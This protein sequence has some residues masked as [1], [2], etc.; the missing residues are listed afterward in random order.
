MT[1]YDIKC[2]HK[3]YGEYVSLKLDG[4]VIGLVLCL[5][6]TIV[7]LKLMQKLLEI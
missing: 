7:T 6:S 2:V 1:V 4:R 5:R 3:G